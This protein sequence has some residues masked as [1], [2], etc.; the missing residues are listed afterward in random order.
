M[1]TKHTNNNA[2]G[3]NITPDTSA[4]ADGDV[5][6]GLLRFDS[7]R[8]SSAIVSV[9]VHDDDNEG[10]VFDL[11]LFDEEPTTIAD[12]AAFTPT[13]ADLQKRIATIAVDT[14]ATVNSIK[15]ATIHL[16]QTGTIVPFSGNNLYGYLITNGSTPTYAAD[17][18][19]NIRLNVVGES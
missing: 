19:I 12:N 2:F 1:A 4:Y 3:V 17:K 6:G 18:T 16:A 8:G 14:Y 10:A 9:L 13:I 7:E 5:V 15:V 11:Y